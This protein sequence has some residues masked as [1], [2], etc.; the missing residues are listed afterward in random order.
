MSKFSHLVQVLIFTTMTNAALASSGSEFDIGLTGRVSMNGNIISSACDIN[1]GDGYQTIAMH[2]ETRGR[3][4]HIGEG[5]PQFFSIELTNCTLGESVSPD[6]WSYLNVI[7]DGD[8]EQGMFRVQGNAGGVAL[9]LK[10]SN[11]SVI[12]PGQVVLWQQTPVT[13]NRMDYQIKLKSTM[14]DLIV[15]DYSAIIRYRIEYF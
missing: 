10:N 4:K 2:T 15:G 1:T 6:A 14:R 12:H 3:L 8:E 5:I 9:E 7:F 13:N 11:G